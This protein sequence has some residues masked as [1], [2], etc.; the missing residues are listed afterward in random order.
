MKIVDF[1]TFAALPDGVI[2]SYWDP[3]LEQPI[4]GLYRRGV[5]I[6]DDYGAKDYYQIRAIAQYWNTEHPTV[7]LTP[8]R[9]G[10]Y[11]YNQLYLLSSR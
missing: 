11:N 7:D 10:E 8:Q 1:E 6:P 9:W 3:N 5:V 4:E 2:F